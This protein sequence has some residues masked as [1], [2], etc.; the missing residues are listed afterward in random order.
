MDQDAL[1]L[2]IKRDLKELHAR[3]SWYEDFLM[4]QYMPPRWDAPEAVAV[5]EVEEYLEKVINGLPK[6]K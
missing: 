5:R 2:A 3:L 1:N 6:Q 4:K